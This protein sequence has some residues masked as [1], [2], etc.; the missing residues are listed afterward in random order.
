[1]SNDKIDIYHIQLVGWM[2]GNDEYIQ[3][4]NDAEKLIME[5]FAGLSISIFNPITL[6][7]EYAYLRESMS[8]KAW[9]FFCMRRCIDNLLFADHVIIVNDISKSYGGQVELLLCEKW[10]IE[11]SHISQLL[12]R[13]AVKN[14]NSLAD[15]LHPGAVE[16]INPSLETGTFLQFC[17]DYGLHNISLVTNNISGK[18]AQLQEIHIKPKIGCAPLC[19]LLSNAASTQISIESGTLILKWG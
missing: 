2:S 8:K 15:N 9:D 3:Q 17:R 12:D 11:I 19:E 14:V 1:M 16:Y 4:F 13:T 6:E 18:I 5:H 10:K 7:T